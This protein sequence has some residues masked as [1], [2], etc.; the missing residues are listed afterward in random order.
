MLI[1][2]SGQATGPINFFSHTFTDSVKIIVDTASNR[3]Y[4]AVL[5]LCLAIGGLIGVIRASRGFDALANKVSPRIKTIRK[6][7]YLNQLLGVMIF[8]DDYANALIAGPVMQPI[9]DRLKISREKLAYIVDSTAAPVVSISLVSSW[10]AVE[11]SVINQGLAEAGVEGSG[12]SLFLRSIPFCF[13]CIFAMLFVFLNST[14]QRDFGPM[15]KAEMRARSGQIVNPYVDLTS[16]K[17]AA[18][19]EITEDPTNEPLNPGRR[20]TVVAV[21]III[22]ILTALFGFY[23]DGR[24]NAIAGGLLAADAPFDFNSIV[25]AFENTDTIFLVLVAAA[26]AGVTALIL[27]RVFKLFSLSSG[28]QTWV[29]GASSMM[30]TVIVLVLA[31]SLADVIARLGTISYI[32]QLVTL[33]V[34]WWLVPSLL[35]VACMLTSY[36]AGSF[37]AM[38]IAMPMAVPIAYEIILAQ[39]EIVPESYMPICIAAVISGGVFG[40][41]A[42]PLT[43]CTILSAF[44]SGC[45]IMDHVRTQLPYGMLVAAV[46]VFFGLIPA[47]LW[48]LPFWVCLLLGGG[49]ILAV[50]RLFGR[51]PDREYEK[52]LQQTAKS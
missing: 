7:N 22:F 31:W 40:D 16:D 8:F 4:A 2:L 30:I 19:T 3:D 50:L 46:S 13:Y 32:V 23:F 49:V 39:P 42:S 34:V 9:T 33:N 10:V 11:V 29:D 1:A 45:S 51:N 18:D 36:A 28:V 17:E 6:A 20:I 27:G 21:P 41:H 52:T 37:G 14:T 25:I 35:F 24:S 12:Y 15:L 43:D 47:T 5:I 44:S 26:F 38:F 48:N